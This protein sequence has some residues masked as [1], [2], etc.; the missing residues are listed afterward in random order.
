MR[1]RLSA[2]ICLILIGLASR[3]AAADFATPW[4][5]DTKVGDVVTAHAWVIAL[6]A[7]QTSFGLIVL[8]DTMQSVLIRA[9]ADKD[10]LG[11][12]SLG[13][14][15]KVK[16]RLIERTDANTVSVQILEVTPILPAA[17]QKSNP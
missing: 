8:S 7:E 17:T 3:P 12:A 5:E 13:T 1:Y 2:L 6:D 15:S 9:K 11:P 4:V 10:I 14:W 16:A